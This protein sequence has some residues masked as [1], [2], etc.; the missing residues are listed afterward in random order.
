MF[1]IRVATSQE[2][3]RIQYA[4]QLLQ[5]PHIVPLSSVRFKGSMEMFEFYC[6]GCL[7]LCC[8]CFLTLSQNGN[9]LKLT[10]KNSTFHSSGSYTVSTARTTRSCASPN[11]T[12]IDT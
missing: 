1:Q 7:M 9:I 11:T 12:R 8:S 4:D 10:I 3:L 6:L 5:R 2:I